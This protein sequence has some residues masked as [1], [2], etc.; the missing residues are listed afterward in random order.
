M[1]KLE[2]QN[3]IRFVRLVKPLLKKNDMVKV[4]RM[5]TIDSNVTTLTAHEQQHLIAWLYNTLGAKLYFKDSLV[6][7]P[8]EFLYYPENTFEISDNIKS[9]SSMSFAHSK[10]KQLHFHK[11]FQT[12]GNNAFDHSDIFTL[13]FDNFNKVSIL[14]NTFTDSNIKSIYV[15]AQADD[16]K[17]ELWKQF[18]QQ[19]RLQIKIYKDGQP[20]RK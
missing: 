2:N 20:V 4:R 6:I 19:S 1:V 18:F 8:Q 3:E 12:I 5:L 10:I 14:N 7:F 17:I 11:D 15:D 13:I 16:E 9:L